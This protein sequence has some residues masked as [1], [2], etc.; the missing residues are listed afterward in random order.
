L[1]QQDNLKRIYQHPVFSS[2]SEHP[3]EIEKFEFLVSSSLF[4]SSS[5]TH[6]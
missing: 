4:E 3:K 1:L 6:A 2:L 5:F